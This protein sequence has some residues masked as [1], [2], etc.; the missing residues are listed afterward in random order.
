MSNNAPSPNNQYRKA[1]AAKLELLV[2]DLLLGEYAGTDETD[3][4]LRNAVGWLYRM[5]PADADILLNRMREV[6][7]TPEAEDA[8]LAVKPWLAAEREYQAEIKAQREAIDDLYRPLRER[9]DGHYKFK[10]LLSGR[11][12]E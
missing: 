11:S 1:S 9:L 2:W 4:K 8:Y 12:D 7:S 5:A 3:Q 6:T 10:L